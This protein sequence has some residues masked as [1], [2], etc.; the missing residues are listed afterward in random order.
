MVL[1]STNPGTRNPGREIGRV[2]PE[3]WTRRLRRLSDL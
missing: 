2:P 3:K 1:L